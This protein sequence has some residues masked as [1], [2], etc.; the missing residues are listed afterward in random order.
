MLMSLIRSLCL[1][2]CGH[3]ALPNLDMVLN[4]FHAYY[5]DLSAERVGLFEQEV[6]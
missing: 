3:F 5:L 4:S 2:R 1:S 6:R